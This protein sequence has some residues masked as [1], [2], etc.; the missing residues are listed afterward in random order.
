MGKKT[1]AP[2]KNL[3]RFI[4][5][6]L[7]IAPREQLHLVQAISDAVADVAPQVRQAM[8]QY[9]E[10]KDIGKRMLVAWSEGVQGLRD[11]S[12][13]A[14][15]AWAKGNAFEGFSE[16]PKLETRTLTIGRSPLLGNR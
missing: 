9:P 13:Y 1:W 14:V 12:L 2:G 3:Q 16:P 15:G 5:A 11:Q 10:F 7:G 6:T 8:R 4:A